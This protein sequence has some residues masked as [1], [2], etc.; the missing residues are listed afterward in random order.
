ME[1]RGLETA[2]EGAVR[3]SAGSSGEDAAAIEADLF[4]PA[5][6]NAPRGRGRP[7]GRMNRA[8]QEWRDLI[9]SRH[10][11]PLEF[12]AAVM[13]ADTF[14][15]VREHGV[16]S[17]TALAVR[18]RAAEALLPYLHKKLPLEAQLQVQQLPT[19]NIIDQ[20]RQ[21]AQLDAGNE[22]VVSL[23]PG[24]KQNQWVSGDETAQSN[25]EE[26]N[27]DGQAVDIAGEPG[28]SIDNGE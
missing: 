22:L 6:V 8:T 13:E 2:V 14:D 3:A 4:G 25:V 19:L 27:A 12:L 18:V 15:L 16:E 24:A 17:K 11:S 5:P 7:A 26:S 23:F 1:E 10:R 20:F 28:R 9:L 21:D